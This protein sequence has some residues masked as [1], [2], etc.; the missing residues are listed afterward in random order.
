MH[1]HAGGVWQSVGV[2]AL[3][4]L[5]AFVFTGLV[6]AGCGTQVHSQAP[7]S[8]AVTSAFHGSPA[9]LASLHA[10]AN[11]LLG[12]GTAAFNARMASLAGYPVVVNK[13]A[14]W[15]DPCQT[16]FPAFQRAAVMFG[17]RVAFVGIDGKDHNESAKAF[18]AR[19]PVTYP[20]YVDPQE[21]I[22]S[23]IK[24][25]TYYPQTVYFD[26]N[27]K[28]VFDHAGPYLTAAALE[29]DIRRYVLR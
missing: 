12:G 8:G 11:E 20:S 6:L 28:I 19:F 22:A 25:S 18:L 2:P 29:H 3:R 23:S 7:S 14:S 4:H 24:A 10:Q 13:W 26:A 15:C 16:E 17:K 21:N 1:G 5:A 27:H 9:P